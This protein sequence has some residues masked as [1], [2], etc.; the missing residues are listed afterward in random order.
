MGHLLAYSPDLNPIEVAFS[1]IK[2]HSK[3]SGEPH[4]GCSFL[5]VMGEAL[6]AVTP[7]DARG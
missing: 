1:K 5:E 2:A 6:A 3:E 7:Q 4:A